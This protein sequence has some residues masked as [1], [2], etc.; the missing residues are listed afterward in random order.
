MSSEQ[1][2]IDSQGNICEKL[3][4]EKQTKKQRF[5]SE[6]VAICMEFVKHDMPL[7]HLPL[8]RVFHIIRCC[9]GKKGKAY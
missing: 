8:T 3:N 4:L 2:V 7:A 9:Q 1:T 6:K 5:S